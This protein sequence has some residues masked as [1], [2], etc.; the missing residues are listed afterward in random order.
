MLAGMSH[1][2]EQNLSIFSESID[3]NF[4]AAMIAGADED[5][6]N[7]NDDDDISLDHTDFCTFATEFSIQ[8]DQCHR[9]HSGLLVGGSFWR[10]H[11]WT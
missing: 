6:E 4:I 1:R 5:Y 7:T 3:H 11:T 10:I 9:T 2:L 8:A